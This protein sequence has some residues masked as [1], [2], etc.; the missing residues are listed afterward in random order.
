MQKQMTLQSI[1]DT[2][3]KNQPAMKPAKIRKFTR[4]LFLKLLTCFLALLL[5]AASSPLPALASTIKPPK[6]AIKLP[7]PPKLKVRTGPHTLKKIKSQVTFKPAPTDQEITYARDLKN[8]SSRCL[9][10]L[11]QPKTRLY[12]KRY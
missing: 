12:L 1:N 4:Q 3:R 5:I 8:L 11:Y 6:K 2:F 10:Q 7:T 9:V